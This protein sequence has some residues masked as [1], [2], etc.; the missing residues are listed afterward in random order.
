MFH[1]FNFLCWLGNL[2]EEIVRFA[3]FEWLK[4][5]RFC[6]IL[7]LIFRLGTRR[8]KR[9]TTS[10]VDLNFLFFLF[11]AAHAL[12]EFFFVKVHVTVWPQ[13]FVLFFFLL[14]IPFD[15]CQVNTFSFFFDFTGYCQS[16]VI[17]P[18]PLFSCKFVE[19]LV[20]LFFFQLGIIVLVWGIFRVMSFLLG[21]FLF[22]GQQSFILRSP[23]WL[24]AATFITFWRFT[25]FSIK[26]RFLWLRLLQK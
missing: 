3:W 4:Y 16:G 24:I 20:L 5:H 13:Q 23:L 18:S 21:V 10:L 2:S 1:H 8:Y 9:G 26:L 19:L 12:V 25:I 14:E 15:S 7:S 17:R 22:R 11:F 6:S